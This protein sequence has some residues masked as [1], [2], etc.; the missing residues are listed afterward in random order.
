MAAIAAGCSSSAPVVRSAPS[1]TAPTAT[2]AAP[3]TVPTTIEPATTPSA[4]TQQVTITPATGLKSPQ[5]VLV[6]A[7]ASF[8][9]AASAVYSSGDRGVDPDET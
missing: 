4:T 5:T 9:E 3:T 1:T 2:T 8:N 7:A 6:V